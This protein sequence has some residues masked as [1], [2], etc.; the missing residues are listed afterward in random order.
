MPQWPVVGWP[1]QIGRGSTEDGG[2]QRQLGPQCDGPA[3]A[4]QKIHAERQVLKF[5]GAGPDLKPTV[6]EMG[7]GRAMGLL[8]IE[9][10]GHHSLP[11]AH[12]G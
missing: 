11:D 12:L 5:S 4:G 10:K 8:I 3:D 7:S 2:A 6:A 1:G 9:I